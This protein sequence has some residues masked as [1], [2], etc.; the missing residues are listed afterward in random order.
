MF[1]AAVLESDL[2]GAD[3][4]LAGGAST[5]CSGH[6]VGASRA[7]PPRCR[8]TSSASACWASRRSRSPT[9]PQASA[10]SARRR[11]TRSAVGWSRPR[12]WRSP[13]HVAQLIAE[14]RQSRTSSA[15]RAGGVELG[16]ERAHEL[17]AEEGLAVTKS[18]GDLTREGSVH[19]GGAADGRD[20][21]EEQRPLVDEAVEP[22][23]DREIGGPG[24]PA[25]RRGRPVARPP[26]RGAS[27]GRRSAGTRSAPT[28]PPL[29]DARRGGAQ[30]AVLEETDGGVDDG[31]AGAEGAKGAAVGGRRFLHDACRIRQACPAPPPIRGGP[32]AASRRDERTR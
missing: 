31:L 9:D 32:R 19:V 30:V 5:A 24:A 15:I 18:C 17:G 12:P 11:M 4:M 21:L 1:D 27:R 10:R 16:L 20:G 29:G 14:S 6:P 13:S 2:A 3:A 8:R 22:L 26:R 23:G 7:G 28:R 25:P